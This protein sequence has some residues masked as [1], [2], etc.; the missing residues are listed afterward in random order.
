MQAVDC[1]SSACAAVWRRSS[2]VT[3]AY[4][5]PSLE[6]SRS[7]FFYVIFGLCHFKIIGSNNACSGLQMCSTCLPRGGTQRYRPSHSVH[8]LLNI[9]GAFIYTNQLDQRI[10]AIASCFLADSHS[11]CSY[12]INVFP[13][14]LFLDLR[15]FANTLILYHFIK[16]HSVPL[17]SSVLV[18][19]WLLSDPLFFCSNNILFSSD[20]A[21][22]GLQMQRVCCRVEESIGSNLGMLCTLS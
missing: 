18:L 16:L 11:D 7:N 12:Q 9:P 15:S 8:P 21:R 4:C 19:Y 17:N 14:S 1:R 5:A 13:R 20:N 3:L 10:S 22:S 6:H 2:V